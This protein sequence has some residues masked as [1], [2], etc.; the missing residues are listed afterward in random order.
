MVG[1]AGGLGLLFG[2]LIARFTASGGVAQAWLPVVFAL[3]A[4]TFYSLLADLTLPTQ[5]ALIM[6]SVFLVTRAAG[7]WRQGWNSLLFAACIVLCINPFALAGSGFWLSFGAV[8]ALLWYSNWRAGAGAEISTTGRAEVGRGALS[9]LPRKVFGVHLYM[10]LIMLP[11]GGWFFGGGSLVAALANM[12]MIPF[13]GLLIVPLT[14]MGAM[15]VLLGL[16]AAVYCWHLAALPLQ[17]LLPLA[18]SGIAADS[19]VFQ[20]LQGNAPAYLM[21][22][23]G[24]VL[25]LLPHRVR[26]LPFALLMQLP[27]LLPAVRMPAPPERA[28]H[29]TVFDVG[30]GTAVL[31]RSGAR[32]L[33]YD[34]GPGHPQGR[35]SAEDLLLPA[36]AAARIRELDTLVIS[37]GDLDHSA[38]A[39]AVLNRVAVNRLRHG[40]DGF[41]RGEGF[42]CRAGESWRWPGGQRFRFLSPGSGEQDSRNNGSCVL[43]VEV[44]GYRLLLAGDIERGR[45]LEAVT[46]WRQALTSHW[47]LVAHHGSATSSSYPLLKHVKPE[48]GIVSAGYRN[49]FRHPHPDVLG[50]LD[51]AGAGVLNTAVEGALLFT[52][53]GGRIQAM[54][55]YRRGPRPYWW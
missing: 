9:A 10:S 4:A 20:Q 44:D 39:G 49:N 36:L 13:V 33:L 1:L 41:Y 27:L 6:L 19:A 16:D 53:A 35:N 31:L 2:K 25:I 22:L 30:Q 12:L 21:A 38:G 14:L 29:V 7:L 47:L 50:R 17:W 5:R 37:H 51:Q 55:A 32:A 48:V 11:L 28:L 43:Q 26:L 18:L 54:Q 23:V 24:L 45:E 42:P 52:V 3:S 40:A 15:G 34:T 46:Y 8:A